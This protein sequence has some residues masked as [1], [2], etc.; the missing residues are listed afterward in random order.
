MRL[1]HCPM[2]VTEKKYK[3]LASYFASKPL[4]LDEPTQKKPNTRKLVEQPWQQTKGEMWDE[5]TDT[6]CNLDFIQAKACAKMT[7]ELVNDFNEV[8]E[9]I[10][11]NQETIRDDKARQARMDKY[12]QD[13][14]ACA[15]GKIAI[16]QLKIPESITP[17]TEKQTDAEI[18]RI[19]SNPNRADKLKDFLHFLGQEAAYLQS[20]AH[21]FSNYTFQQAW[22]YSGGGP[23]G[24]S[25]DRGS[26]EIFQSLLL[27]SNS[28]RLPYNPFPRTLQILRGHTYSV[29]AISITTDGQRAI[30]GS[31][32]KTCILWDLTSGNAL[33]I[34]KGHTGSVLSISITPDGKM[35]IS[36]SSDKTCILWN[37]ITGEML[38]TLKGHKNS[39]SA[40]SITPDGKHAI[41]GA[42]DDT[43]ILWDLT[44]GEAIQTLIG[45]SDKVEAVSITPDCQRAISGSLD[46]TCI[47]WDL[48]SDKKFQI[49]NGHNSYV[50]A[51][52][53]TPD[54]RYAISG[55]TDETCI[56]WDLTTGERLRIMNGHTNQVMTV[57]I[58]PDGRY[59]I[60]GSMDRTC[61]HWDLNT[62][63][64]LHIYK[65]RNDEINAISITPDGRYAIY[66]SDDGTCILLN[67][68]TNESVKT[69]KK[70][71][72]CVQAVDTTHD[73]RIAITGSS[74]RTCIVWDVL[75]GKTLQTLKGHTDG[76]NA[77]SITP[78]GQRAFSGSYDKT[79]ILWD[80]N[81][82]EALRILKGHSQRVDFVSITPD[83]KRA[84]SSGPDTH[85]LWDLNTG[86]ALRTHKD[87]LRSDDAIIITPD[88]RCEISASIHYC[89]LWDMIFGEK[90][91]TLIFPDN[92]R[93]RALSITPDGRRLITGSSDNTC[94]LWDIATGEALKTL[95]GHTDWVN[96]V[97]ITPDGQHLISVSSDKTCIIWNLE[98]AE[99]VAVFN[100]ISE[101]HSVTCFPQ[102]VFGGELSGEIFILNAHKS[103]LSSQKG[104]VTARRIWDFEY[105]LYL[106]LSADCPFCGHRFDP[107]VSVLAT[108]EKITNEA[109]LKPEQSP[110]LELPNETWEEPGLFGNCPKCGEE[111][112]YNP[113]IAERYLSNIDKIEPEYRKKYE[114]AEIAFKEESWDKAYNLYLKLVQQGKFDVN[115]M[116]Y[117][118]A[119]CKINGLFT[120]D[121]E[122]VNFINFLI[123]I[124]QDKGAGDKAQLVANKL[125]ERLDTIKQEELVKK[126]AEAP[127]W[128]KIILK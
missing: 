108:I 118:M 92:H 5:V 35:A 4:Y 37:L 48:T 82:G 42:D 61:I 106:P 72:W 73:G 109:G 44:T 15:K 66:G 101:I 14:I 1:S 121:P 107:P 59:A 91:K 62:G 2:N 57:A 75:T 32:D 45:H 98:S 51:V 113:F 123:K 33:Q 18:E 25:T 111:L 3:T 6:L 64:A 22:N 99:K 60:S 97:S 29:S 11:D 24:K 96:A 90:I 28:T 8:L 41:S 74:D 81:S 7:Y 125:K 80:L 126:K 16:S 67:L 119:I 54:G 68:L 43:C 58:T 85:I 47:L 34:L 13:L 9:I 36:G 104:I 93:V 120:N 55:S 89:T 46:Q 40:V 87:F 94:R 110:C 84:I 49:L 69:P 117:N 12:T 86:E 38:Q 78:D 23:V 65:D 112:K 124:L 116:R 100:T 70:H 103:L 26:A 76:V 79:C 77:V 53:I 31:F 128:R 56:W 83:G 39:I 52:S 27:Y 88:G 19:K 30:S 21:K 71:N 95:K 105:N 102:G 122:I 20:Y 114:D 17:W 50:R 115:H 10:P 127:W 63:K